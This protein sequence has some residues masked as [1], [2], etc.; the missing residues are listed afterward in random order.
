[1]LN[2]LQKMGGFTALLT[3]E[4]KKKTKTANQ[5]V[6]EKADELGPSAKGEVFTICPILRLPPPN[7]T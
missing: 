3:E 2:G 7:F 6:D 1:M 5:N 4:Q